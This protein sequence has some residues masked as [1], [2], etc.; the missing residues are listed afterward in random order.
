VETSSFPHHIS[1]SSLCLLLCELKVPPYTPVIHRI[2]SRMTL[3][4]LVVL[5]NTGRASFRIF[6]AVHDSSFPFLRETITPHFSAKR[7]H[8]FHLSPKLLLLAPRFDP[9]RGVIT[10]CP[11]LSSLP[12]Y[13]VIFLL[14]QPR[15]APS[16][17]LSPT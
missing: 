1:V 17:H 15:S 3:S 7:A 6:R 10:Y 11:H 4:L 5:R 14:S 2:F 13:H 12:L 16:P 8:R 9:P